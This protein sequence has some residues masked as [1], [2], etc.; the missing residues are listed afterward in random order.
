[1]IE[2]SGRASRRGV[3]VVHS[4]FDARAKLHINDDEFEA[5]IEF[6][7]ETSPQVRA[8]LIGTAWARGW[9]EDDEDGLT[10]SYDTHVYVGDGL[11]RIYLC[12]RDNRFDGFEIPAQRGYEMPDLTLTAYGPFSG[13]MEAV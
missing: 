5:Y 10:D 12:T 3:I 13:V 2:F 1:M 7:E 8:D 11:W 6:H 4:A 9:E